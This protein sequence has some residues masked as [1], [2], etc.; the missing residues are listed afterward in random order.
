[1]QRLGEI[2]CVHVVSRP[3]LA[4]AGDP[5]RHAGLFGGH[6]LSD[7]RPARGSTS[8][9]WAAPPRVRPGTPARPAPSQGGGHLR[10]GRERGARAGPLPRRG[11][12]VD[13]QLLQDPLEFVQ[14][15][16]RAYSGTSDRAYIDGRQRLPEDLGSRTDAQ[17]Y[18]LNWISVR[19]KGRA[20]GAAVTPAGTTLAPISPSDTRPLCTHRG[21]SRLPRRGSRRRFVEPASSLRVPLRWRGFS[22]DS[23]RSNRS[24]L[25]RVSQPRSLARS[26]SCSSSRFRRG[27]GVPWSKRI[28]KASVPF[29]PPVPASLEFRD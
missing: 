28:L 5:A 1:M 4:D 25:V 27:A 26:M 16:Y 9:G 2:E 7:G 24:P 19:E 21:G 10:P 6:A 23:A 15:R 29:L 11:L 8:A 3:R 12:P 14:R 18:R 22:P 13:A 17:S 20:T